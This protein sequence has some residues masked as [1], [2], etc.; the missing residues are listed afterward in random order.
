MWME[1]NCT[2]L[3]TDHIKTSHCL[4]R[5]H[6]FSS[7]LTLNKAHTFKK[8]SNGN[9]KKWEKCC[10]MGTCTFGERPNL[11]ERSGMATKSVGK[12]KQNAWSHDSGQEYRARCGGVNASEGENKMEPTRLKW[13]KWYAARENKRNGKLGECFFFH[14]RGNGGQC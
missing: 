14:E 7:N 6:V 13:T 12:G 8:K 5:Q 11:I 2:S 10:F 1:E 9:A 3:P 4:T